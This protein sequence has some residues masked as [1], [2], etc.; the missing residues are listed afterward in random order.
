MTETISIPGHRIDR[1]LARGGMAEV[2]L[3]EQL[4]LGRKVAIKVLDPNSGDKEFVERFMHEAR[5]VASLNHANLITIYDFGQLPSGRLFLSMEYLDGGDLEQRLQ[6]GISEAQ[7]VKN[8]RELANALR[9]VH[10]KGIIHRDIKPANILFRQ[11]GSLVLTDFGIAKKVNNDVSLTQAGMMVG[12]AAYGSPEQIQGLE[13]DQHTDVYSVGVVFL[14]MLT[15]NN[16]FRDEI[17][18]NTA[19]NHMQM[20]VPRLTGSKARFQPLVDKMLAKK[21]KL[22]YDSMEALLAALDTIEHS[23][24][25][26][27]VSSAS[28]T[29]T[30]RLHTPLPST[31]RYPNPTLPPHRSGSATGFR[32]RPLP[33]NLLDEDDLAQ[34]RALG[35]LGS[36][37]SSQPSPRP[38]GSTTGFRTRPLPSNLLDDDDV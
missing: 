2:Y 30:Q 12:S 16:P 17:F 29:A 20:A 4:S 19:M 5:L 35:N 37:T 3:A 32:S 23:T 6:A 24:A 18:I 36:P 31:P 21:P 1:L 9:F 25:V 34:A 38:P 26:P 11:D 14:E 7:A 33:E 27:P 13:L 28:T 8:L 10:S 22:R 15:G